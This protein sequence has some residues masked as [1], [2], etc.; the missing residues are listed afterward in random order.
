LKTFQIKIPVFFLLI[1]KKGSSHCN[2]FVVLD[3][4][5]GLGYQPRIDNLR[6]SVT[7]DVL[8]VYV[9]NTTVHLVD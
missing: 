4:M 6:I 3:S 2:N 8:C 9:L 1:I 5:D 7:F